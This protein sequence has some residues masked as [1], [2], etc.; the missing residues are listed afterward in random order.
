[1]TKGK[2]WRL[3]LL[4][5]GLLLSATSGM[6]ADP[7]LRVVNAA[8]DQDHAALRTLL[9]QGADVNAARAARSEAQR[10][11]ALLQTPHR[12]APIAQRRCVGLALDVDE[13]TTG[14]QLFR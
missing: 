12:N 11:M 10:S 5:S 3:A 4:C 8:Q 6:A 1:M 13:Q 2:F 14:F 9:K 7:D